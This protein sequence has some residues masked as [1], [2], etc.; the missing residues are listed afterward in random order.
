MILSP[1]NRLFLDIETSFLSFQT[2]YQSVSTRSNDRSESTGGDYNHPGRPKPSWT[3][4]NGREPTNRIKW[5][6]WTFKFVTF[7]SSNKIRVCCW[8]TSFCSLSSFSRSSTLCRS[9]FA[10]VTNWKLFYVLTMIFCSILPVR[11]YSRWSMFHG[12]CT[13]T[14]VKT[15]LRIIIIKS[16]PFCCISL[17]ARWFFHFNSI[18]F[19]NFFKKNLVKTANFDPKIQI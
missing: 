13:G 12:Q 17:F 14:L 7:M 8:L 4:E 11:S 9:L 3:D 18:F 16:M 5:V 1:L 6:P 2:F 15:V 19:A 10:A